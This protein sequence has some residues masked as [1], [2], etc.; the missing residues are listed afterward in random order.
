MIVLDLLLKMEFL[1]RKVKSYSQNQIDARQVNGA[2][3]IA[4]N[5]R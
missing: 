2:G 4:E 5:K 1:S 3:Y